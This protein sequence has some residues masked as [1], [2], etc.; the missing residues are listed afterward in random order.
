LGIGCAVGPESQE[1]EP[2]SEVFPGAQ[3]RQ[4][5]DTVALSAREKYPEAQLWQLV[6]PTADAYLPAKH[7]VHIPDLLAAYIPATQFKQVGVDPIEPT[8][9]TPEFE[10]DEVRPSPINGFPLTLIRA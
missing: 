8:S 2:G 4:V 5:A 1:L 7:G 9:V 6:A 3:A 10:L